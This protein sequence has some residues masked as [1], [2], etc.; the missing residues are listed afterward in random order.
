MKIKDI[1]L[2]SIL[3][4]HVINASPKDEVSSPITDGVKLMYM[5]RSPSQDIQFI[6]NMYIWGVSVGLD[7]NYFVIDYL[8]DLNPEF[9]KRVEGTTLLELPET[10]VWMEISDVVLQYMINNPGRLHYPS[11]VLILDALLEVY[12]AI[13]E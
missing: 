4:M 9:Q 10:I 12:G 2:S 5:M 1:L 6:A 11:E 13:K 8:T 3:I 7:H